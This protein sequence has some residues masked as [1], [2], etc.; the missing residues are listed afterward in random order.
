M[1][2][3]LILFAS[4][5]FGLAGFTFFTKPEIEN[6]LIVPSEIDFENLYQTWY[7]KKILVN[8]KEDKANYPVNNDELTLNRDKSV[9]SID[10]T[11][12]LVDRGTWEIVKPDMYI[13][14]TEEGPVTFKILKLTK[15]EMETK[16]V[17]DE[18]DM[19]IKYKNIK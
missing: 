14:K 7:V 17:T 10:R 13:I 4:L 12:N 8:G 9:V 1:S 3:L 11:Y 2:K 18:I 6:Q 15:E 19:V 5:F 16:M